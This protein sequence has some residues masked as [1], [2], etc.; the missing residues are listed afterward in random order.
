[1]KASK[2]EKHFTCLG[3]TLLSGEPLM[4]VVTIIDGKVDD[5][6]IRSSVDV[7]SRFYKTGELKDSNDKYDHLLENMGPGHQ[8]PCGPT[9]SYN[10]KDIPCMV[11][12][13]PGGGITATILTDIL[14]TLDK[15]E[16]F[17]HENEKRPFLLV[18]GHSTRF[19]IEFLEYI[20]DPAHRWSVCIGVPY[21]TSLWQVGDSV[22]QNGQFKVK[23]TQKKEQL[24]EF[25]SCRQMGLDILPTDIIPI[26][27]YAWNGSFDNVQT[28]KKSYLRERLVPSK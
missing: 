5:L 11:A 17:S 21:G 12:F 19:N 8:Y 16:V 7:E 9:Y 18:D 6:L 27:N 14:R 25:Q 2:K 20:N 1:L 10:G 23:V 28:N 4:C 22:H 13:N 3:L 26:V 24:L 15:I